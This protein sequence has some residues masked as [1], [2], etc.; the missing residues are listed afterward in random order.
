MSIQV[1]KTR[2]SQAG[3]I[4]FLFVCCSIAIAESSTAEI[5][6]SAKIFGPVS[7]IYSVDKSGEIRKI[8][9]NILWRDLGA[10]VADDGSLVFSSN[11]EENPRVD[12]ARNSEDFNVYLVDRIDREPKK[13]AASKN[14]ELKPRFS[15]DGES[16]AIVRRSGRQQL[17]LVGSDGRNERV[18]AEADEI[19][20]FCWSSDGR[21]LALA[22]RSEK[23]TGIVL[24]STDNTAES[25]EL[26]T[27]DASHRIVSARWSPDGKKIAYISHPLAGESRQLWVRHLEDGREYRLSDAD[28][29][30]QQ[31][32]DW[33]A[34][35]A[36]LLYSAL[37]GYRFH[38]D[39]SM[40]KKVYEGAMHIFVSDLEGNR[41]QLTSGEA[42]HKSPVFS[43]DGE[44]IAFLYARNL[45]S[46]QL[47]L[48]TM[49]RSG[50]QVNEWF[51]SVARSSNLRW[52][53]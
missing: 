25:T 53:E 11:R 23:D 27:V 52:V 19:Y 18:L 45:D 2:F 28:L 16:I 39:E 34:D 48:R 40:H 26:K 20:D 37:V 31:P 9:D 3:L 49:D 30:V 36:R 8:T 10:D 7:N 17:L 15:P 43:P 12:L 24:V 47:S 41:R 4:Y 5:V 29:E 6:F 33:S 35:S 38:Y 21:Q 50:G 13:I 51:G 44:R 14:H 22:Q 32:P 1:P 46:R 42:L